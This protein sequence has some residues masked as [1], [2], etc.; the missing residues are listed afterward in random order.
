M[1]YSMD[2]DSCRNE[3]EACCEADLFLAIG[4]LGERLGPPSHKGAPKLEVQPREPLNS[5]EN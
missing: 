3:K 4:E 5:E 2:S 1:L